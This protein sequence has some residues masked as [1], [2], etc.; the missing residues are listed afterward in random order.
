MSKPPMLT[1]HVAM[2]WLDGEEGNVPMATKHNLSFTGTTAR[3]NFSLNCK[4]GKPVCETH[5]GFILRDVN[6]ISRH[7]QGKPT[8]SPLV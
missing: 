1:P 3:G 8:R 7:K 5:Y 6:R 2:G 4:G